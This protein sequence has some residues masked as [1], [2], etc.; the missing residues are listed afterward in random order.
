MSAENDEVG[1]VDGEGGEGG[2]GRRRRRRRRRGGG[3]GA[4]EGGE[5]HEAEPAIEVREVSERSADGAPRGRRQRRLFRDD[6]DAAGAAAPASGKMVVRPRQHRKRWKPSSGLVRRRR[7]SR[8]EISELAD[9]FMSMPEPLVQ[10]LYRSL[11]GQ[12]VRV[13]EQERVVQLTVRALAQG[14]RLS[15]LLQQVQP[16]DRQALAALIQCGG[17]AHADEFHRELV[18]MLGG[19]E[20]DW[21]RT[22][23]VLADRGIV[24]GSGPVEEG[25]YYLVPEPLIDSLLEHLGPELE[26]PTFEHDDIRVSDQRPF[27]PPLDFSL[28]TLATFM[29]QHPPKLTQRQEVFKQ[30]REELDRFFAQLWTPESEIFQLHYDFLM[31]HGMIEL[32]GDRVSVNRE[33]VEE[34]LTLEP[35]DQRDLVFRALE[36]RQAMAEWVLWAI[37]SAKGAWVPEAPLMALYRRWKRGEDWRERFHK[38]LY[39]SPRGTEREGYSF[40]ALVNCGMLEIGIW[41][42]QKVYR[43]SARGVAL[44]DPP[45]DEGFAKF[46][47]T[48]NYEIIAPAG[49]APVLLFRL[50]EIAELVGCDRANTYRI[51]EISIE[52]AL[53]KGWRRDELLEFLREYSQIGLPSNVETTLRTWMGPDG[54]VEFH[55]ITALTVHRAH[56]QRFESMRALRAFVVHRF[57]PG[58]YAVDRKRLPEITLAL[59][60]AGLNPGKVIRKYPAD[61]EAAQSR[62][63]LHHLLAEAREQR[64]DPVARAHRADTLPADLRP[65]PGSN[66]AVQQKRREAPR[67]PQRA[68]PQEVR[69]IVDKALASSLGIEMIYHSLKDDSRKQLLVLPEKVALNREGAAVLVALDVETGNRLSYALAQIERARTT[70]KRLGEGA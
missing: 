50:G 60:E 36:K 19:R 33:V 4:R 39:T 23:A 7:F 2:G 70:E 66:V 47:L 62:E 22:M 5:R 48:P 58:L 24:C 11:G 31:M 13:G 25:F 49:L 27:C 9:Y 28:A 46:Y 14:N 44:L 41:G 16:R 8:G 12:P 61:D 63:R 57:A 53:K 37:H 32:R 30:Q 40:T 1:P 26:L 20:N 38:G 21:A 35:E 43:L 68:S 69:A 45:E 67:G 15:G 65:V 3:G 42:Q 51:T 55:E 64:E 18:L 17:I 34:W 56:I 59:V 52:Q 10:A 6:F 54:E 29:D